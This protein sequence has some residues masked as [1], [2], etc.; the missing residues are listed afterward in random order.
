MCGIWGSINADFVTD[1]GRLLAHRGPDGQ[2]QRRLPT[3]GGD[4]ILG[5]RRLAIVDLSAAGIQP[6]GDPQGNLWVTF[7]GEIYNFIQLR[8]QLAGLG[9]AF[10]SQTDTEVLLHG[11]AAWG[12]DLWPRLHGMF[13]LALWDAVHQRLTLVRDR[14]GKKPL[15]YY[16]DAARLAFG[17]EIKAVL[18]ARGVPR[19]MNPTGLDHFLTYFY[20]PHP[21]TAFRGIAKLPPA[22]WMR[23][24]FAPDGTLRSRQSRYWNALA[25]AAARPTLDG[26]QAAE[27]V[28]H[29]LTEA[30]RRRLISDV[31]LGAFLSGGLDS[32]AIVALSAAEL[33][34]P[35]DAFSLSF[36]NHRRY[37][38][39][40]R[41]AEV[42]RR[43][44][45][46]HFV[47]PVQSAIAQWLPKVIRHFDEPFGNPT[48]LLQYQ[49]TR[50]AKPHLSVALSGD[51]GDELFLGYYRYRGAHWSARYRALPQ[52]AVR[53]GRR[54]A[55]LLPESTSGWH[56]PRRLR[57]FLEFGGLPE[58]EAY[59]HWVGYFTA[60]E[61]L[62]LYTPEFRRQ[63]QGSTPEQF[64]RDLFHDARNLDAPTRLSYVDLCSFLS[65]NV[66][67]YSDR[68]S[69]AN[70]VEVRCPFADHSLAE[71]CLAMPAATKIP[72]GESKG[73]LR[74]ALAHHL[75]A[76]VLKHSK[77]G[78][79]PP[80]ERWMRHDL[81]TLLDRW[82]GPDA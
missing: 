78:F 67:E 40:A 47:L 15:F 22:T 7:N 21:H 1:P 69:M 26:E 59:A 31:P 20:F 33:A 16:L 6:M 45:R 4:L 44:A 48:A 46:Q 62:G 24:E 39:S 63:V 2:H 72:A 65:C 30:V 61:K 37:D 66:L 51:G 12:D 56:A 38:E 10:R 17:S 3:P 11:Y 60:D 64:L 58:A 57:E 68:M 77:Q 19:E 25:A 55:A 43:Y 54:L 81:Q 80:L 70:S 8:A 41:A 13:A 76:S 34:H 18:A 52:P 74:Q 50:L 79:S 14:I 27:C 82:L 53:A 9:Y 75:P 42:A 71:L 36:P 35:L 29:E 32:S 23:I 73:L 5:H 28:R 49:L